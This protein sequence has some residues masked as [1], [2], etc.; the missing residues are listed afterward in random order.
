MSIEFNELV[1][2]DKTLAGFPVFDLFYMFD[3]QADP[4]SVTVFS[5]G[6]ADITTHWITADIEST[7]PV[8]AVR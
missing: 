3:D 1:K 8:E 6:S 2:S 4:T 5:P 7:V